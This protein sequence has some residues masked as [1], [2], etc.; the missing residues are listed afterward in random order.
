MRRI[1]LQVCR[2]AAWWMMCD[3]LMAI[4]HSPGQF[5]DWTRH[6]RRLCG[7]TVMREM[8]KRRDR[9]SQAQTQ[10]RS[11]SLVWFAGGSGGAACFGLV[12]LPAADMDTTIGFGAS[13]KVAAPYRR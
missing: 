6:V 2:Q 9:A 13:N 12:R 10:S 1:P 11:G 3:W 8:D 5:S 4:A 7:N